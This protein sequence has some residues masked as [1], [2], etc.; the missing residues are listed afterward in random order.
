[1][2]YVFSINSGYIG[3]GRGRKYDYGKRWIMLHQK[4]D[5]C[6]TSAWSVPINSEKQKGETRG[7]GRLSQKAHQAGYYWV[8]A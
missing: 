4:I 5:Y 8:P 2:R 3:R 1:M 7:V 6:K